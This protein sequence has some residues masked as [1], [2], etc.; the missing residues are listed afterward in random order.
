M[1]AALVI[2]GGMAT[3]ARAQSV[4]AADNARVH[5]GPLA[6]S[7]AIRLTSVGLDSNVFNESEADRPDR[8]FTATAS[9]SVDAWLRLRRVRVSGRSEFDFIY[10]SELSNLRAIDAANSARVELVLNR[11]T[12][13]VAGARLVTR[14][15]RNLE[16]DAPVKRLEGTWV[17][18]TG[19]RLTPKGSI[20]VRTRRSRVEYGGDTLY[21]GS[22]LARQLN[23]TTNGEGVALWYAL[24][25]LTTI[26][27]D[28]QQDRDR[29]KFTRERDSD[30]LQVLPVVEFKPLALVSGRAQVGF[31]R[32]T[33]LDRQ[34]P[35]FRGT[36]ALVDLGYTLLGRTRFTVQ[37]QRDLAYSYHVNEEEYLLAGATV[38]VSQR[39]ADPWDVGASV[40]RF[41][42]T[43]RQSDFRSGAA[44]NADSL[45][46]TV[47]SYG[48]D[49]GYRVGSTRLGLQMDYRQRQS[50][51]S[52]GRHYERFRITSSL[53]YNF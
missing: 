50:D 17:V 27:L 3:P 49:V 43:Y 46:E 9:P 5:V 24:T 6:A 16:I 18:G 7:P 10:F 40:G 11:L 44:L 22:D 34:I 31:R 15:R 26:G 12:P 52:F 35:E 25:P 45:S 21:L 30:S 29:F 1:V 37:A 33:F 39:L 4:D 41:R 47:L 53:T 42:L 14:H 19:L 20:D 32:R 13:Y 38:S 36:V 8:D 23:R 51:V 48:A 28:V 2:V